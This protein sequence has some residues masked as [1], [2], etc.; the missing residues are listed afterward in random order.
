[1]ENLKKIQELREAL[2]FAKAIEAR[3]DVNKFA[4][5]CFTDDVYKDEDGNP[6]PLKQAWVHK[7]IQKAIPPNGTPGHTVILVARLSGKSCQTAIIRTLFELGNDPDL[8]IKIVTA[9][10]DL[11][12]KTVITLKD[13]IETNERL[14]LVF[15]NLVP[16]TGSMWS[17]HSI[18]VNRKTKARD[19]SVEAFGVTSS[20]TGTRADAII[21]DDIVDEKGSIEPKTRENTKQIYREVWSN[22]LDPIG[23]EIFCGTIYHSDDLCAELKVSPEYKKIILPAVWTA[24]AADVYGS[25]DRIGLPIWPERWSLEQLDDRKRLI[26]PQAFARQFMLE[27]QGKEDRLFT[28]DAI[29]NCI[30]NS[31]ELNNWDSANS[32]ID[33]SWVRVAGV[34]LASALGKK[35]SYTVMFTIA[36]SKNGKRWPLSIIRKRQK[37]PET[38][39]MIKEQYRIHKHALILVENNSFQDAVISQLK[40]ESVDIPVQGQTTGSQKMDLNVGLPSL[41][42]SMENGAWAIPMYGDHDGISHECNTCHWVQELV[43]APFGKFSDILMACWLAETAARKLTKHAVPETLLF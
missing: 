19:A 39:A 32:P 14:K 24:E 12:M 29:R 36:V 31:Y 22:I 17:S 1:M 2:L 15:P 21:F 11:A 23:R 9:K 10:D 18:T 13:H 7:E 41:A 42:V 16:Q 37:F 38:I 40:N 33:N 3:T 26:G 34:D 27:T 30:N 8:R 5:F 35:S 25:H 28:D 20:A 4:E 6:L 43:E